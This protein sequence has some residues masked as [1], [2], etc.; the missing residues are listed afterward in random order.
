MAEKQ[1]V[2]GAKRGLLAYR[3]K[4]QSELNNIN[5]LFETTSQ[6]PAEFE[7]EKRTHK[8]T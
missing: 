3:D 4:A 8:R 1:V 7:K 2:D 6:Q 5:R